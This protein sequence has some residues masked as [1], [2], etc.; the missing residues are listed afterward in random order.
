MI[1]LKSRL[2]STQHILVGHDETSEA[3]SEKL[4][5]DHAC[6]TARTMSVE[7][8]QDLTVLVVDDDLVLRKLLSR[9]VKKVAPDWKIEEAANGETA[10]Q[11]VDSAN[12]DLIFMV[13]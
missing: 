3:V 7:L 13:R 2:F 11:L 12:Y 4:A 6:D 1:Q 10:L 8:P 5:V 9:S